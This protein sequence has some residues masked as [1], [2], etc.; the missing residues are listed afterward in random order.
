MKI[1]NSHFSFT[2]KNKGNESVIL[3]KESIHKKIDVLSNT[4]VSHMIISMDES[5]KNNKYFP[6]KIVMRR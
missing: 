4:V 3:N 1:L 5:D 6:T 2:N